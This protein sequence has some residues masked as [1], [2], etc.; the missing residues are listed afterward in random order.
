MFTVVTNSL[1]TVVLFAWLTLFIKQMGVRPNIESNW[2]KLF[3]T[4]FVVIFLVLLGAVGLCVFALVSAAR[5]VKLRSG[6]V[7][8]TLVGLAS[9]ATCL[10][11]VGSS[12]A[13]KPLHL[14]SLIITGLFG[15]YVAFWQ[16]LNRS[17]RRTPQKF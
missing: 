6:A 9:G 1:L 15:F 16:D 14:S 3:V 13:V 5:S 17:E 12:L 8:N 2:V 10:V 11:I 7:A 4:A